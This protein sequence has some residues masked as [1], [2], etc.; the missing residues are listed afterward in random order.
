[1]DAF[2]VTSL[3]PV[4]VQPDLMRDTA[5]RRIETRIL[6][7]PT[8]R[9]HKLSN[10]AVTRQNYVHVDVLLENGV[11]GHGEA[12]TLGGPRWSEESV[13]AI[14]VNIDTYLAPALDRAFG[15][16]DRGCE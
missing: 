12:S 9:Q 1:M 7:V 16:S 6:D 14:K 11:V 3:S 5:I 4:D 10:T 2:P 13:E 15:M 8:L